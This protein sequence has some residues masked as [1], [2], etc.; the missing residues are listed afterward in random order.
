MNLQ[1]KIVV[2]LVALLALACRVVHLDRRPMHADEAVQGY[3]FIE[4]LEQGKYRYDPD[5]YHGPTLNY[6][7]LPMAWLR[8]ERTKN[9]LTET[10]LRFVPVIFGS[11][12]VLLL[13]LVADGLGRT[14]T[15]SAAFITATA[16]ALVFY[17]RY[18]I[19]ETLL[20]FFTMCF[21]GASWK[22]FRTMRT[23][24]AIVAG[25]SLGLM[26]ATKET[27]VLA[28][29]AMIAAIGLLLVLQRRRSTAIAVPIEQQFVIKW[30]DV[31]LGL[32][33]AAVV[34]VVFYSSFFDNW[35]GPLDS[36]LTYFPWLRRAKGASPHIHPWWFYLERWAFFKRP[37]GNVWTELSLIALVGTGIYGALRPSLVPGGDPRLIRFLALYSAILTAVYSAISYKT[38][39][40][41]LGFYHGFCI[42]GGVGVAVLL[43]VC[44]RPVVRA[45]CG[46]LLVAGAVHLC[47]ETRRVAYTHAADRRNPYVYAHTSPDLLRLVNK[48]SDIARVHPNPDRFA[49]QV[50]APG[51]DY[52]PLPWYFRKYRYTG[53][54]GEIPADPY[55][56]VMVVGARFNAELDE[57]SNKRWLM[58]GFFEAR[59]GVFFELYV[60]LE[61][62]K[63]YVATLPR[64]DD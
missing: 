26:H 49:I 15:V 10:T 63:R 18:Y 5:E 47:A 52:W 17:S 11:G 16:P 50:M 41:M 58:V 31:V 57:K 22:Y 36:V 3:K 30:V 1:F 60:E 59:P 38:P 24:W 64:D 12:L 42:M 33:T 43:H 34:S 14:A 23:A 62:W 2:C 55:A 61:L 51:G 8:G 35:R 32:G 13:L 39:W 7:T 27:F 48:I 6:F 4:L 19:H 56:P 29:L 45:V 20:V 25:A 9:E 46:V 40:C 28:L 21:L 53:W 54:W 37:G 44:R